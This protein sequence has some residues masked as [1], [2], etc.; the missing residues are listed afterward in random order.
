MSSW[1]DRVVVISLRRRRDRLLKFYKSFDAAFTDENS[2]SFHRKLAPVDA[3]DGSLVPLPQGWTLHHQH[4]EGRGAWGCL[5]SHVRVLEDAI[6]SGAQSILVFEDDA[7]FQPTFAADLRSFMD[8]L[9]KIDPAWECV[10]LGGGHSSQP[11]VIDAS[12]SPKIVRC[13]E[14]HR[15][16]AYAVRGQF[17]RD[18]YV[19]WVDGKTHCDHILGRMMR[20]RRVYAPMPFLVAQGEGESDISGHHEA[21]RFWHSPTGEEV[22]AW[23]DPDADPALVRRLHDF[24]GLYLGPKLDAKGRSESLDHVARITR[25]SERM[26]RLGKW[27][28]TRQ[29][30]CLANGRILGV[31]HPVFGLDVV[32]K[33]WPTVEPLD[34][35]TAEAAT[36]G[37]ACL[38]NMRFSRTQATLAT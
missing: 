35:S 22:A 38:V 5:R 34:V 6:R 17:L 10:M 36:K 37:M 14:T 13:Y 2:Q 4:N 8:R 9:E 21:E 18:L 1:F 12:E 23:I 24:H 16:H 33:A 29:S 11:T 27:I 31:W 28:A 7:V 32:R 20:R 30:E 19:A 25:E 26:D 3:V 15:T